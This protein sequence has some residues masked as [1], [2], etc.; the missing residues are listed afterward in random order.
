M[1]SSTN[2]FEFIHKF[3]WIY[4]QIHWKYSLLL[5]KLHPWYLNCHW[6]Q[7]YLSSSTNWFEF[8]NKLIWIHQQIDLNS[9]KNSLKFINEF[10]WIQPQIQ[11][12]FS[13]DSFKMFTNFL[14]ISPIFIIWIFWENHRWIHK[15][16]HRIKYKLNHFHFAFSK[17]LVILLNLLSI[18]KI[19]VT[20]INI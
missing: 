17:F 5:Y 1:N 20:F 11:L 3:N 18:F 16:I 12:N 19:L 9:L 15:L 13:T 7:I 2:S 4:K 8:I 14:K 10:I 6:Q